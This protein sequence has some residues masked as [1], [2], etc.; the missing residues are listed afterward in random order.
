MGS[1]VLISEVSKPLEVDGDIPEKRKKTESSEDREHE[2]EIEK[3]CQ[4]ILRLNKNNVSRR[5][6][7]ILNDCKTQVILSIT[8]YL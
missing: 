8:Q 2:K 6:T 4:E 1:C 7:F 3:M 5:N